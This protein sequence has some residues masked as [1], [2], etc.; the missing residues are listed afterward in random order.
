L[1]EALASGIPFSRQAVV[2]TGGASKGYKDD[3]RSK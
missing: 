3:L 2:K 1:L